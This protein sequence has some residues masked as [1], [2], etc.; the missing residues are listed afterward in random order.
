MYAIQSR[1][2]QFLAAL[3]TFT[4]NA[5][6]AP[7]PLIDAGMS[8]EHPTYIVSPGKWTRYLSE[9]LTFHTEKEAFDAR[10]CFQALS[11]RIVADFGTATE[12]T[13]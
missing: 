1:K 5:N 10:A 3:P 11:C 6:V 7:K 4:D 2:G 12:H 13:V 9:M 8:K